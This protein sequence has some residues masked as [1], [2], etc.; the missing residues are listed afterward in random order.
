MRPK[1]AEI[2]IDSLLENLL[3]M[4]QLQLIR[5]VLRDLNDFKI[6]KQIAI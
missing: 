2:A 5:M 1:A 3:Q 4:S 6:H